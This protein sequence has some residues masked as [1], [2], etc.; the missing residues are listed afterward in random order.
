MRPNDASEWI[1]YAE[2]GLD[3]TYPALVCAA[4]GTLIMTAHRSFKEKHWEL[5]M[6]TKDEGGDWARQRSILRSRHLVYTQFTGSLAWG[7]NHKK[8]HLG[9]RIYEVPGED[10]MV[11]I[12]TVG[13]LVSDDDGVTWHKAD[14]SPVELPV[15]AETFDS[16]SGCANRPRPKSPH[17]F[18]GR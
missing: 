7:P 9:A 12:T 4:G 14:G 5:E 16:L 18:H 13:Y 6:W 15:T 2:F 17:R 3:L 11:S 10:P 1:E 8:L